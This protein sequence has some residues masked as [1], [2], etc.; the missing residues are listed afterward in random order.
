MKKLTV[1]G[2]LII[3]LMTTL[4]V[5]T[6]LESLQQYYEA[7]KNEDIDKMMELTDFS[8]VDSSFKKETKKSLTALAEIFDTKYFE[9]TNEEEHIKDK[10]A[11]V[12]YH[13]KTELVDSSGKSTVIEDD[14]VAVMTNNNG[15]KILYLQPKSTFEQNMMLRQ[16]TLAM[17][18]SYVPEVDFLRLETLEDTIGK[19]TSDEERI[20]NIKIGLIFVL[21]IF[22]MFAFWIWMLIDCLTRKQ[23]NKKALWIAIIILFWFAGALLYFLTERKKLK[24]QMKIKT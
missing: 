14:F 24:K 5:A 10:N 6:P 22:V 3:L 2:L 19:K 17:G 4:V 13:L 11:L 18:E 20:K 23:V 16:T 15:W 8:N 21:I 7:D 9:I 12:Y 1:I